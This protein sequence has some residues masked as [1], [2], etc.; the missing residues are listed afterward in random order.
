MAL[1]EIDLALR[2]EGHV[3]SETFL[4]VV[5]SQQLFVYIRIRKHIAYNFRCHVETEGIL[6]VTAAVTYTAK[7]ARER[8]C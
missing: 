4:N 5:H 3:H 1:S 8:R 6:K 2:L 7:S